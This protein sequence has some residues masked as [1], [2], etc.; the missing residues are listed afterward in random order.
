MQEITVAEFNRI[1][2]YIKQNYGITLNDEK[3]SLVYSRLR[4]TLM[5]N[6]FANFTDYFD[7][8]LKDRSGDSIVRFV[9]KITTNHTFFMR[10]SDHFDYFRDNVLPF[11]ADAYGGQKD[12]RLWCA[13][14][15][16]G[17]EAVTLQIIVQDFFKKRNESWDTQMLATDISTTVLDKAVYGH[18]ANDALSTVPGH[19]LKEYFSPAD[20]QFMQIAPHVRRN[21]IYRKFNFMHSFPF[22][23]RFHTIFCRNVM[24]YFDAPTRD[25]LVRK[26][27]EATEPGGYLFIGHSESLN[28]TGTAFKYVKPAIYR[29]E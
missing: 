5:E 29:K 21:I 28:H 27:Y 20:S 15:S 9:D 1:R 14:C 2:D 13:G 7:D 16:S 3:R 24:I 18:Y 25:A 19:W 11:I 26:F 10:E 4:S 8:L 17:E 12:L 6:G 22:R 23:K